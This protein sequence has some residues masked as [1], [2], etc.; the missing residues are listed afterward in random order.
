MSEETVTEKLSSSTEKKRGPKPKADLGA[1]VKELEEKLDR[2][3]ACFEEVA[4]HNGTANHIVKHGFKR[5][6]PTKEDM[7]RYN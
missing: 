3:I 2:L 6:K 5:Y 4:H 1:K 7:R